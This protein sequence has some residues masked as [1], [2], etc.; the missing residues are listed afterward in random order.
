MALEVA[1]S[2]P[3]EEPTYTTPRI[4]SGLYFF[5]KTAP[6]CLICGFSFVN[7]CYFIKLHALTPREVVVYSAANGGDCVGVATV[8]G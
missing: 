1:G 3:V 8:T 2:S 4:A 6:E 7:D 5:Q